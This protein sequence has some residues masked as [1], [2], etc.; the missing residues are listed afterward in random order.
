VLIHEY[1]TVRIG[2]VWHIVTTDAPP[3][4]ATVG[5]P[6]GKLSAEP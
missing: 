4:L 2:R 1:G 6:L 3:M 5:D